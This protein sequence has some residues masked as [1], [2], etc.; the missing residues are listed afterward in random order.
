MTLNAAPL[1]DALDADAG[2]ALVTNPGTITV[3]L[4]DMPALGATQI[5]EFEVRID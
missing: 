3:N 1:S 4:G 5:I 2:D